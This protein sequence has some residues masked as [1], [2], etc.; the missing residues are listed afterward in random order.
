VFDTTQPHGSDDVEIRRRRGP[1]S[2]PAELS[3]VSPAGCAY[4]PGVCDDDSSREDSAEEDE[5]EG[6]P[7]DGEWDEEQL[8]DLG[9]ELFWSP[10]SDDET[11]DEARG[12]ADAGPTAGER[13][14]FALAQLYRLHRTGKLP[15]HP[16]AFDVADLVDVVGV[17]DEYEFATEDKLGQHYHFRSEV[18]SS[19]LTL[20]FPWRLRGI[21]EWASEQQMNSYWAEG[22]E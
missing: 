2:T 16:S 4:R 8:A 5:P 19:D 22:W 3:P 9:R 13:V 20:L 18:L 12:G 1:G 21:W 7:E 15:L 6:E 14:L 11:D 10:L 17:G